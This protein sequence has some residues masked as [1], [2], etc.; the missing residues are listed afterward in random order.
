MIN[1][2]KEINQNVLI[3]GGCGFLGS[4]I[5]EN[6]LK[7]NFRIFTLGRNGKGEINCDISTEIPS[8]PKLDFVIH[9]AGKAHTVPKTQKEEKDFFS[10][11]LQGTINLCKGLERI[12]C[13][14]KEFIFISTVAV[15]GLDEGVDIDENYPLLGTSPYA[16]SKI[17]A[18]SFLVDWT[19][20]RNITLTI[21]RLPLIAGPNPPGNL[22]SMIDG[23]KTGRYASIGKADARKSMVWVEDIPQFIM[24]IKDKGGIFNLTDNY[25]PTFGELELLIS[26]N[27]SKSKPLRIPLVLAKIV[28]LFGDLFGDKFPLNSEKLK[29]ITSTLTFSTQK[30]MLST[31]WNPTQVL[32]KL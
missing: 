12:H 11:N 25:H 20:K 5:K 14:P 4:H 13:M 3:T 19:K 18:E 31:E 2:T 6:I 32:K 27:L 26:K 23:I 1:Y 10:V 17:E 30:A 21:L 29:K 8:L 15:Y 22:G 9:T 7:N 24:K 28:A 16:K